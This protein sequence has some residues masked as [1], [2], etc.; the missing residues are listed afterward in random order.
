MRTSQ[1]L[2]RDCQG[3]PSHLEIAALQALEVLGFH[4]ISKIFSIV[5]R[6]CTRMLRGNLGPRR[7]RE[8]LE[9]ANET[10]TSRKEARK[11][12]S[13]KSTQGFKVRASKSLCIP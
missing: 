2:P 12:E 7:S 8:E 10:M 3:T 11:F 5:A 9:S 13:R 1:D 6:N 4:R